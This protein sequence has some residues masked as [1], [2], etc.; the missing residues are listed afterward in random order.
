MKVE[1]DKKYRFTGKKT[2]VDFD[3]RADWLLPRRA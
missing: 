2:Y 1:I 3:L